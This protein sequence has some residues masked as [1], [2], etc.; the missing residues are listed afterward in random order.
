VKNPARRTQVVSRVL[1]GG[2]PTTGGPVEKQPKYS[3]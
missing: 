2:F 3:G 1:H